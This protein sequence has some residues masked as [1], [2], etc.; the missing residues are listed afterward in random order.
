MWSVNEE[1]GTSNGFDPYSPMHTITKS[2]GA[3]FKDIRVCLREIDSKWTPEEIAIAMKMREKFGTIKLNG[4]SYWIADILGRNL[5]PNEMYKAQ[6]FPESYI[7]DRD[8]DGNTYSKSAQNARVGNSV[9]PLM[10]KLL[11]QGQF[12]EFKTA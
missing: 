7:I 12:P 2:A 1:Y 11:V 5:M 8:A 4:K 3:H 10:A 6:D 9:V